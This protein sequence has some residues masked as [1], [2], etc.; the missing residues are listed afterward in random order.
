MN[1]V[2]TRNIGLGILS[3]FIVW[4]ALAIVF[5][6]PFS[7][8]H[9]R[10]SLMTYFHGYLTFFRLDHSWPFYAPNVFRGSILKYETTSQSG[11][12]KIY[13]LTQAKKKFNHAYFRYTNFYSY[14]F[15]DLEYTKK[16]GYDKEVVRYLCSRHDENIT[17]INFI[18]L[19]QKPFSHVDYQNGK[20]PLDKEYLE[21]SV[22][23][24]YSCSQN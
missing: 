2:H 6:G 9:L 10:S 22:I 21:K 8:S 14:L 20:R 11:E 13:P 24:P 16:R 12:T 3:I 7:Y 1:R 15:S 23:G 4:H 18:L 19:L 17:Q 5:V